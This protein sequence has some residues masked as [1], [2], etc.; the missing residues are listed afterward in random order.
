MQFLCLF[1][2]I[3]LAAPL[4]SVRAKLSLGSASAVGT[5]ASAPVG[6]TA[7]APLIKTPKM[8]TTPTPT[9]FLAYKTTSSSPNSV[10]N[11]LIFY[12]TM[13]GI[14]VV[15]AVILNLA[16]TKLLKSIPDPT[17]DGA[18]EID[19]GVFGLE[20]IV[21]EDTSTIGEA[22]KNHRSL[23]E[24]DTSKKIIGSLHGVT[25]LK[26]LRMQR[27]AEHVDRLDKRVL[28]VEKAGTSAMEMKK[29]TANKN[30]RSDA[31]DAMRKINPGEKIPE[32]GRF[33]RLLKIRIKSDADILAKFASH[34]GRKDALNKFMHKENIQKTREHL[35]SDKS[36]G[37]PEH[38]S[39]D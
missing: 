15:F 24:E 16:L 18:I 28:A 19:H 17:T 29:I 1:L 11:N 13:V 12:G 32:K 3:V 31:D 7:P 26:S 25:P 27:D 21:E 37:E 36:D 2:V 4:K 35:E 5:T 10:K 14:V 20:T 33:I 30:H 38:F 23:V 39:V 9:N 22:E 6:T 8:S 34:N